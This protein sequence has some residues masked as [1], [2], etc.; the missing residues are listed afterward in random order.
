MESGVKIS[1]VVIGV[2]FFIGALVLVLYY[3]QGF[4]EEIV[5]VK[6]VGFSEVESDYSGD[7]IKF[8]VAKVGELKLNN[9]K[10]FL[11][12]VYNVPKFYGC[13]ELKEGKTLQNSDRPIDIFVTESSVENFKQE[14]LPYGSNKKEIP[15]G[16]FQKFNLI[17]HYIPYRT[18]LFKDIESSINAL[19][20]YKIES[21]GENP[22][23]SSY[24]INYYSCDSL[25]INLDPIGKVVLLND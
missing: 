15:S 5:L 18:L 20:V 8:I 22:F 16:E 4:E 11:P 3:T 10:A 17:A 7:N 9:S 1:L 19:Y 2:L 14:I 23:G 12:R 25:E 6:A 21:N 24:G 13:L